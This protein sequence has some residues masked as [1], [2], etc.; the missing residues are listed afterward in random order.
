MIWDEG[1][2]LVVTIHARYDDGHLSR[3]LEPQDVSVVAYEGQFFPLVGPVL[4]QA[5]FSVLNSAVVHRE[6]GTYHVGPQF[7][8]GLNVI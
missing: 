4:F 6:L 7:S 8:C 5:A 3:P 2:P 1:H